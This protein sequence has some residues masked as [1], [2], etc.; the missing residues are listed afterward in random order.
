[1]RL[2][3]L[4]PLWHHKQNP[5]DQLSRLG[6]RSCQNLLFASPS[7]PALNLTPSS[8]VFGWQLT[9]RAGGS[10]A[11]R[12]AGPGE[13]RCPVRAS[14]NTPEPQKQ[15]KGRAEML[16]ACGSQEDPRCLS[17]RPCGCRGGPGCPP[18]PAVPV[19]SLEQPSAGMCLLGSQSP[20]VYPQGC[21]VPTP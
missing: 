2:S 15:Q 1:M 16:P 10:S 17:H 7:L 4:P 11:A 19:P 20:H 21:T 8:G 5:R 9:R 12:S 18:H 3:P 14:P 13:L 6:T